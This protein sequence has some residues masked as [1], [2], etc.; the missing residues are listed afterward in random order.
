M[1]NQWVL[2]KVQQL[3]MARFV[4]PDAGVYALKALLVPT[5]VVKGFRRTFP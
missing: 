5:C 3:K 4:R 2:R 1:Q